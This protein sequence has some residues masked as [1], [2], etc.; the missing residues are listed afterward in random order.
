MENLDGMME[1]YEK[2]KKMNKVELAAFAKTKDV[3][4]TAEQIDTLYDVLHSVPNTENGAELSDDALEE[5]VGGLREAGSDLFMEI[6]KK[7]KEIAD[8]LLNLI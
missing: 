7:I 8:P 3:K 1:M 6:F 4:L 2:L 5:A